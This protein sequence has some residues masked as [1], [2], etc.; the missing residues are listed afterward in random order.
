MQGGGVIEAL[1]DVHFAFGERRILAGVSLAL[2]EGGIHCVLGPSGCGK[3][4]LLRL[5]AGLIA[6]DAGTVSLRPADCA[7]VFQDNRLLPW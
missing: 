7:M 6:P 5:L 1:R 2:A 4:T 3:S